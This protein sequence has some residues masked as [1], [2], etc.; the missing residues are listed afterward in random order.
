MGALPLL[1]GSVE[2]HLKFPSSYRQ[3]TETLSPTLVWIFQKLM[4]VW[5][6][7]CEYGPV[8]CDGTLCLKFSCCLCWEGTLRD[9]SS[10][11]QL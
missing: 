3:N 2:V 11:S 6:F 8:G 7:F 10:D 4:E 5:G 1:G 9:V